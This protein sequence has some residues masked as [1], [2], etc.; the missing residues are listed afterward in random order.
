ML[1]VIDAL[2]ERLRKRQLDPKLLEDLGW[3]ETYANDF[4]HQF[5]RAERQAAE[6]SDSSAGPTG[7]FESTT[8]PSVAVERGEGSGADA[9]MLSARNVRAPDRTNQLFE[10]GR[11]KISDE[12]RD[13]LKAY[14]E[15]LA[16]DRPA[17]Q[18]AR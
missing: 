3:D 5:R 15:S 12:Y 17:T 9:A 7:R 13:Y 10:V 1:P 8:R 4:V 16:K 18:P 6:P 14:Y 2:E 11:Q